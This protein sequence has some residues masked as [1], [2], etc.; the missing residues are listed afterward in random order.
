MH[1]KADE[2]VLSL[3][4][5]TTSYKEA[6]GIPVPY[7]LEHYQQEYF[8]QALACSVFLMTKDEKVILGRSRNRDL[9]IGGSYSPEECVLTNGADIFQMAYLE[10]LQETGIATADILSMNLVG[11][12]QMNTLNI[13]LIFEGTVFLTEDEVLKRFKEKHDPELDDLM[14]VPVSEMKQYVSSEHANKQA[15]WDCLSIF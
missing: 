11:A 7:V 1:H 9:L 6:K 5:S 15:I 14:F 12:V 4:L 3:E 10:V 8:P 2:K 13:S